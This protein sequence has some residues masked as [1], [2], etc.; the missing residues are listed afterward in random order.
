MPFRDTDSLQKARITL[1]YDKDA[2]KLLSYCLVEPFDSVSGYETNTK[3]Y[4]P[5]RLSLPTVD[6]LDA[7]FRLVIEQKKGGAFPDEAQKGTLTGQIGIHQY[8]NL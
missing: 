2:Q 4:M 8:N 3:Y 1:Y 6:V 7:P 5:F